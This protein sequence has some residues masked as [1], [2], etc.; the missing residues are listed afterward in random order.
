VPKP[1]PV[2]VKTGLSDG[3]FTEVTDGLKEGDIIVTGIKSSQAQSAAAP[4]GGSSP[5]GGGRRGF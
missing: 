2:R 4:P 3:A 1:Q 5:F